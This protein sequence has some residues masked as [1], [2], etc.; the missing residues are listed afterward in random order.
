MITTKKRAAAAAALVMAF[1][2]TPASA[3]A[4]RVDDIPES[5][6]AL[7]PVAS[8][9]LALRTYVTK[10]VPAPPEAISFPGTWR[11]VYRFGGRA[12]TVV[13][14]FG[15]DGTVRKS[16]YEDGRRIGTAY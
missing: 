11:A 14:A 13:C 16:H 15:P 4:H 6:Y 7:S 10:W 12:I 3:P 8:Y 2:L 9:D 1:I 5:L